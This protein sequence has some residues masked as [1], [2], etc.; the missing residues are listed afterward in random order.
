V[1]G[2]TAAL[3]LSWHTI[4]LAGVA[5]VAAGALLGVPAGVYYHVKLHRVL[6]PRGILSERWWVSPVRYHRHLTRA[7]RAQ[8][9]RW[10]YAGG[11][12]FLLILL[13]AA[14]TFFGVLLA[15]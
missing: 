8:V 11:T 5:C 6:A 15:E 14:V 3:L 10:F 4:A 9:L 1:L 12:G 2:G 7:E 13:G